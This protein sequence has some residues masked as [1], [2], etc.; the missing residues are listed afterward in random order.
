MVIERIWTG[1]ICKEK[2]KVVYCR[3]LPKVLLIFFWSKCMK[4][5]IVNVRAT[6]YSLFLL[7]WLNIFSINF[8]KVCPSQIVYSSG[9]WGIKNLKK[10]I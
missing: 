10:M 5:N 7:S 4:T 9:F 2:A 8:L 6:V 1:T 3:K